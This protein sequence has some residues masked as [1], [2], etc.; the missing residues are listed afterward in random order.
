MPHLTVPL[1]LMVALSP[2][3]AMGVIWLMSE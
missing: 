2:V 1:D 3:I